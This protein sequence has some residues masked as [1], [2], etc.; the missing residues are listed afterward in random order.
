VLKPVRVW[1]VRTDL[2][3]IGGAERVLY[4]I[5]SGLDQQRFEPVP[6]LLYERGDFGTQIAEKGISVRTGLARSKRDLRLPLRL[7]KLAR[8]IPPDVLFTTEN[9]IS[10]FWCGILRRL[11]RAKALVVGFHTTR[12]QTKSVRL[13][14][15]FSAKYVDKFVALSATH[16]EFWQ[17]ATGAPDSKFVVIPNGIDMQRFCPIEDKASL[18]SAHGV[19]PNLPVVGLVAHLKAVKNLP[20][21]VEVASRVLQA[22]TPAHFIV[23]G[24][25]PESSTLRAEIENRRLQAHFTLPGS[26]PDPIA[27][28]Q[29]FDLLL[30]TS[31]SEAMPLTIL[32]ANACGVPA[33]AT[34][35]G[36]VRDVIVQG[37]TGYS[38]P[39]GDVEALTGRVLELLRQPEKRIHMGQTARQRAVQQY[40]LDAMIHRYAEL[41]EQLSDIKFRQ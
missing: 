15:R 19:P 2:R 16:Q 33:V 31:H 34:D 37:E 3:S 7:L 36:G 23:V 22:G 24:D 40:S 20:L 1:F 41:F 39:A 17:R 30:L 28:H 29:M 25:G 11:K 27:W 8:E 10:L 26:Q 5:I 4:Q 9:A 21:F 12:F 35:V 32:E 13:A 38:V 14:L 6:V 18:L